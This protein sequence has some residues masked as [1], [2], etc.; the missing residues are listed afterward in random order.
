MDFNG[1]AKPSKP[2]MQLKPLKLA[3]QKAG[4]CPAP[5]LG[6]DAMVQ[7]GSGTRTPRPH[8][9]HSTGCCC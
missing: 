4:K 3:P 7:A 5:Y 1:Q 8:P 6:A 2:Q 9:W